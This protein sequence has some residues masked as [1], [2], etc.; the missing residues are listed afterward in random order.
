MTFFEVGIHLS[1]LQYKPLQSHQSCSLSY[2]MITFALLY[3]EVR[4][5]LELYE[6]PRFHSRNNAIEL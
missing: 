1:C 6:Q 4:A 5:S 2:L 3:S